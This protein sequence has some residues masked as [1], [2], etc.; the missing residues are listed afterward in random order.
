MVKTIMIVDD[1]PDI[2]QTA[3]T[4]LEKSGYAVVTAI[5]GD[6]CLKKVQAGEKPDLI[7]MDIMMPGTPVKEIIPKL[8]GI[9]IAY[10]SVVRTSEA[11][12]KDLM[13]GENI[14]DYIQKPFDIKKLVAKVKKI[15]G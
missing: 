9:K 11:E 4:I 13:K 3:K 12:K 2:R 5:N 6:D 1:E 8:K 7:L 10:L 15:V 14:I